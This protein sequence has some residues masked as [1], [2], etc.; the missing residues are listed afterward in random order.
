MSATS[1]SRDRFTALAQA[2]GGDIARWPEAEREAARALLRQDPQ[3]LG[4]E[5]E[6]ASALDR[7]LD[8]AP[9]GAVDAALLGRLVA[10]APRPAASARRWIAGLGAALGLGVSAMAGVTVGVVLAGQDREDLSADALIAA[11]V[12]GDDSV[13]SLEEPAAL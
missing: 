13:D 10:A 2:Y 4:R 12:G 5:L 7:L 9:A 3:G 11:S 6:D 1:L 8:L